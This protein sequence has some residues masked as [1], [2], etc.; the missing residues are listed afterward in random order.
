MFNTFFKKSCR[1]WDMQKNMVEPDRPQTTKWCVHMACWIPKAT[2]IHMLRICNT[3]CVYSATMVTWTLLS[4]ILYVHCLS[5][6]YIID[7][8]FLCCVEMWTFSCG[9]YRIAMVLSV[10]SADWFSKRCFEKFELHLY[11]NACKCSLNRVRKFL[12]VCSATLKNLRVKF[13][14]IIQILEIKYP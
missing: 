13:C 6:R 7:V 3:Y 11:W 8:I 5:C 1:L 9:V 12:T 4:V 14:T 10:M 2:H